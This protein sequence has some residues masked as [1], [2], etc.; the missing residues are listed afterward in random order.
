MNE[1]EEKALNK[2]LSDISC[3]D[4]I[5]KWETGFNI[6]DVLKISRNEIRHSNILSWLL[7]A[8]GNHGLKDAVLYNILS[9][10]LNENPNLKYKQS[11]LL[12]LDF[13]SFDVRREE[14]HID[15]LLSSDKEKFVFAIENK[16]FTG[17]HDNQLERYMNYIQS[18]FEGYDALYIYLTPSG[19]ESS[20]VDNWV[21]LSYKAIYKSIEKAINN[22]EINNDVKMFIDDYLEILRRDIMEDKELKEICNKIYERHKT[23][24]DLIY[25]NCERGVAKYYRAIRLALAE[26]ASNN[27]IIYEYPNSTTFYLEELDAIVPQMQEPNSSWN[28]MR[29]YACWIE[30]DWKNRIVAHLELGG[31]NLSP[32]Q[33]EITNKLID[34][35]HPKNKRHDPYQYK[36]IEKAMESINDEEDS[37]DDVKRITLSVVKKLKKKIIELIETIQ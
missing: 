33:T 11:K 19:N 25:N 23:A 14:E 13:F 37:F 34:N 22:V 2:F 21:A 4:E 10:L 15:I 3:L 20:D 18:H 30:I 35:G 29:C 17:E 24:L 6:F 7:D 31:F 36:R 32:E 12:L 9:E 16:T 1:D 5:K 26:L 28:T 8:N 27:V